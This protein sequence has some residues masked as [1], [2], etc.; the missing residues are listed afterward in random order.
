M[1]ADARSNPAVRCIIMTDL[2]QNTFSPIFLTGI[3]S[4]VHTK[5]CRNNSFQKKKN[6]M[7]WIVTRFRLLREDFTLHIFVQRNA[8]EDAFLYKGNTSFLELKFLSYSV[9]VHT[10]N[11]A[12]FS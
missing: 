1:L 4:S 8:K 9:E 3:I 7:T 12:I 10:R 11:N 6:I 5:V 2:K